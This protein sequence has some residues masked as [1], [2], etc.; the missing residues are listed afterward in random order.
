MKKH[1]KLV[2]ASASPRRLALLADI[3]VVPDEVLPADI[4]ET[5]RKG[6]SPRPH[7]IRLARE[8]GAVVARL[9]PEACVLSADTVVACGRR[10]LPKAET[11]QDVR[12]C[13]TLLSGRRHHV[14]TAVALYLPDGKVIEKLSDTVVHFKRLGPADIESYVA[15]GEG[16]GKAGGYAIQGYAARLID[17]I[18]GSY[19]GVV[20]LPLFDVAQILQREGGQK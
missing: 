13:L 12:E 10:I 17:F 15:T 3:G 5:V 6:E 19:S 18:A 16:Q 7:A 4:D 14:F 9:R 8:K 11:P 2:L 20:G 1:M